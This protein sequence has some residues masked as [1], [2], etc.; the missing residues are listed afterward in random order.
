MKKISPSL[1]VKF[2]IATSVVFAVLAASG[3]G[4]KNGGIGDEFCKV[5]VCP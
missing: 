3:C 5:F 1:F 4:G 2:F